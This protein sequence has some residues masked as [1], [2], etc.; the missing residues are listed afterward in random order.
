MLKT[1]KQTFM[2]RCTMHTNMLIHAVR[3]L[4][5]LRKVLHNDL[6]A[7]DGFKTLAFILV[8]IWEA[9]TT[10]SVRLIYM[11]GLVALPLIPLQSDWY[12]NSQ[13][14]MHILL[15]LTIVGGMT[16]SKLINVN[17]TTEYAVVMLR[18]DAQR[19]TVSNYIYYLFR[20]VI[21]FL[22]FTLIFGLIAHVPL[23]LCLLLPFTAAGCKVFCAALSLTC[24]ECFG[25]TDDNRKGHKIFE[26][27]LVYVV[28]AILLG[29]AYLLPLGEEYALP[30]PV[31]AGILLAMI[32]AG[33]LGWKK[34]VTYTGYKELTLQKIRKNYDQLDRN[35]QVQKTMQRAGISAD[36]A[37]TS[38]RRGFEYLNELFIK[39]HRKTL[40]QTTEIILIGAAC[41]IV[42]CIVL[43]LRIPKTR[44]PINEWI[45]R[46]LPVL[47]FVMYFL[48][49]G[50]SFTQAMF[51]NCD[52]AMLTY[53]FYKQPKAILR[54]FRIRLREIMKIN[55][56][57]GTLIGC[58]LALLLA[59]SGGTDN[60][61]NYAVVLVSPI[62][63]SMFFSVHYLTIYY[64]LQPYTAGSEIKSPL[65]RFIT[66]A[67]YYCCYLLM[68]QKLPTFAF[69][70][71]CIAF[72]VIYCIVACILVYKFAA[73]TFRIHRE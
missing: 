5:V 70:L 13:L 43:M 58:G 34:V 17:R 8:L 15:L 55:A 51:I 38:R 60:P 47:T 67:T 40:W 19:Y 9:F 52:H 49:R 27:V 61:W 53:P 48:N 44:A 23:W 35:K 69:G 45:M 42:L 14:F 50:L 6:Y 31:S 39:R 57:P 21:G 11:G 64:L 66:A 32:P 25:M 68:Q 62:A 22:P 72:C 24:R 26:S 65:Y 4:P 59:I 36:T 3:S 18:M 2:L 73:R 10:F 63:I 37:I 33:L 29:A 20:L 30:M 71:T 28:A 7:A 56:A 16:N 54:L 1:L 41:A 12:T 46:G